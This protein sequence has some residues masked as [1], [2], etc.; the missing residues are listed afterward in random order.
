MAESNGELSED[1]I[2]IND[3]DGLPNVH[4]NLVPEA[5]IDSPEHETDDEFEDLPTSVIVTNIHD[6]VFTSQGNLTVFNCK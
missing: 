2:I 1:D 5:E 4:P 3:Q 6:C